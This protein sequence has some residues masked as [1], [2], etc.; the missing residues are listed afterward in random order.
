MEARAKP[1]CPAPSYLHTN[2][3]GR[4][5]RLDLRLRVHR[6]DCLPGGYTCPCPK[7]EPG[8]SLSVCVSLGGHSRVSWSSPGVRPDSRL[9]REVFE[10]IAA[11]TNIIFFNTQSIFYV[12][13][14]KVWSKLE[15]VF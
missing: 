6:L 3:Q 14:S 9:V 7:K 8:P 1:P 15:I 5:I 10:K 4:R 11:V 13:I 2:F 12:L